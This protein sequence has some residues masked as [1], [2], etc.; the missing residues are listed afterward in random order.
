MKHIEVDNLSTGYDGKIIAKGLSLEVEQGDYL[1]IVGENGAGKTTL[2]KTI[3][4]L[5]SKIDGNINISER[6]IGYLPQQNDIQKDFPATVWEIVLSGTLSKFKK[7]IFFSKQQKQLALEKLEEL[8][9]INLKNKSFKTLSGG[10]KQRVLLARALCATD[11]LLVLDE[12]VS[13]LD[14]K[15]TTDLYKTISELNNRGITIIMISHDITNTLKDANKVLHLGS[16]KYL[17]TTKDEYL[18]SKAYSTLL[19]N[20]G[21]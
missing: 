9:I 15:T 19:D 14:P 5:I 2:M 21:W 17:F 3:L 20:E 16:T 10:Q 11:N 1:C 12:P 4:G 18:T 7:S 6:Y 8:N 13:G